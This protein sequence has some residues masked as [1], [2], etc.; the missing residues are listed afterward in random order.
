[1]WLKIF[2][3]PKLIVSDS[4]GALGSEEA[5]I[6]AER[7]GT[8]FKLLPRNSHANIVERHHETLRQLIHRIQAQLK[9]EGITVSIHDV[10]SEAIMAK[11]SL[12]VI[13]GYTPYQA[14]L[15]R[16][17]N[18]LL[19]NESP[20]I[21][22]LADNLGGKESKHASRLR[23][24][25]VMSMLEGSAKERIARAQKSQTRV[26]GEQ[27][28]LQV[29]D[30]VDVYRTPKTKDNT[31]WRGPAKVVSVAAVDQGVVNVSWGG[32]IVSCRVQDVRR[33]LLYT[34]MLLL[35]D[36]AFQLIRRHALTLKNTCETYG[37][38]NAESGWQLTRAAKDHPEL[39]YA[40]LKVAHDMFQLANCVAGK[41][42][43][44]A[45]NTN[46][47]MECDQSILIWWPCSSPELYRSMTCSA[48]SNLNL[49]ETFGE[50]CWLDCCWIRL[51]STDDDNNQ[52]IHR[53]APDI[54]YLGANPNGRPPDAPAPAAPI[55]MDEDDATMTNDNSDTMS[56]ATRIVTPMST[57]R[58]QPPPPPPALTGRAPRVTTTSS[59]S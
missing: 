52:T 44:G 19:E 29:N 20:G 39:F 40:L 30:M 41:I 53:L 42:G 1:M 59:R 55:P 2:G 54:P 36:E 14:V 31:G 58:G 26:A 56:T 50:H 37:M 13:N 46:G 15:G 25:A 32:R 33:A 5:A 8:S 11:N 57:A 43:R 18:L 49:K 9:N 21:S 23:E 17:P 7:L 47:H 35:E 16:T 24:V 45:S 10:V 6:W 4:E 27:L 51:F 48:K 34:S 12:L 22:Q 3:V 28:E 38:V